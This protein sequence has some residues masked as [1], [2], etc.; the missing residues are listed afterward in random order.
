MENHTHFLKLLDFT[1]E[2]IQ[3][4]LE[5]SKQFKNLKLKKKGVGVGIHMEDH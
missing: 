1:T 3:Y 4:L 2:E 5:L